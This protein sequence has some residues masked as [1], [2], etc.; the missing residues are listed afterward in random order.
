MRLL[1][2]FFFLGCCLGV[3]F[4]PLSEKIKW[5]DDPAFFEGL[6]AAGKPTVIENSVFTKGKITQWNEEYFKRTMKSTIIKGKESPDRYFSVGCC[7]LRSYLFPEFWDKV[8]QE[9]R[10]DYYYYVSSP[11]HHLS[12]VKDLPLS[13][14][15]GQPG[16]EDQL[17]FFW[18]G[19]AG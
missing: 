8:Y 9:G 16:Y 3:V 19:S 10:S 1:L 2:G 4:K 7:P 18:L 12:L 5:Q 6:R 14:L 15:R 17:S 11:L 13:Y